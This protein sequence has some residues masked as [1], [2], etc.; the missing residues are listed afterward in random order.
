MS[1]FKPGMLVAYGDLHHGVMIKVICLGVVATVG[2][3]DVKLRDDLT[4]YRLDGAEWS[5]PYYRG[6]RPLT[7]T[8]Y[9]KAEADKAINMGIAICHRWES[10]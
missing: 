2:K 10:A 7:K 9:A 5:N 1:E 6:I 4:R 8:L 3:R